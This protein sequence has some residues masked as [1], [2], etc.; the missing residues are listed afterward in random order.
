M[1]NKCVDA[2]KPADHGLLAQHPARPFFAGHGNRV[3]KRQ[4]IE[5]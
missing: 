4:K 3:R 1:S 5:K 2:E